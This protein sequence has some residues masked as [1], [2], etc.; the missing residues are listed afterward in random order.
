MVQNPCDDACK[1]AMRD[2][3]TLNVKLASEFDDNY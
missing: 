1:A 3:R 2:L